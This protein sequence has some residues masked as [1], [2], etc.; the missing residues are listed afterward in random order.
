MTATLRD[1]GGRRLRILLAPFALLPV[2]AA[3]VGTSAAVDYPRAKSVN[4]AALLFVDGLGR[5]VVLL[6]TD[7]DDK[8][9]EAVIYQARTPQPFR[10]P[11]RVDRARINFAG[12][13][14]WKKVEILRGDSTRPG[15]PV[16]AFEV[17]GLAPA[18][19][20][21]AGESEEDGLALGVVSGYA[22][23]PDANARS[24]EELE[25]RGYPSFPAAETEHILLVQDETWEPEPDDSDCN[26]G[27]KCMS[28][29]Q[30]SNGCSIDC[31]GK[32]GTITVGRN[33]S[34]SCG[35][36]YFACCNCLGVFGHDGACV[37]R[38]RPIVGG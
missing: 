3:S 5:E 31:S 28:G 12:D 23:W 11:T 1:H 22:L 24:A 32:I 19:S 18:S 17:S 27:A 16:A 13:D 29:G 30:G 25:R 10:R 38:T 2:L 14:V 6:D 7:N 15:G 8:V 21:L 20:E 37:C 36:G 26:C 35:E 9:N 33:C 34:V 4:A